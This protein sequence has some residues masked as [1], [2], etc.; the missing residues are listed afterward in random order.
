MSIIPA[1]LPSPPDGFW[2]AYLGIAD[3]GKKESLA[4]KRAMLASLEPMTTVT[5]C[6]SPASS[7]REEMTAP[8]SGLRSSVKYFGRAGCGE[9]AATV[10]AKRMHLSPL[11]EMIY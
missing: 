8:N 7:T 2:K 6:E 5:M 1:W 3:V 4:C 11:S 10:E 9:A